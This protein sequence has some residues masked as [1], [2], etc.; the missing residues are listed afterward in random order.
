ME[1][2]I[3]R[4]ADISIKLTNGEVRD[5]LDF[6]IPL[7]NYCEHRINETITED[8]N[9]VISVR[10]GLTLVY[11]KIKIKLLEAKYEKWGTEKYLKEIKELEEEYQEFYEPY[12]AQVEK[13]NFR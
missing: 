10:T 11:L 5:I 7:K 8:F 13:R 4:L 2:K 3:E 6:Y 1:E 12:M 9:D